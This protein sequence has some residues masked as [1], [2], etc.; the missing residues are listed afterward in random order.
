MS[1]TE[2]HESVYC[3][4]ARSCWYE[5]RLWYEATGLGEGL[6]NLNATEGAGTTCAKMEGSVASTDSRYG[7]NPE[8]DEAAGWW[9]SGVSKLCGEFKGGIYA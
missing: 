3:P 7:Q 5:P 9:L 1:A 6:A 4:E 2:D 8:K